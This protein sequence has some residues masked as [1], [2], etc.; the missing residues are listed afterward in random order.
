MTTPLLIKA[1]R[2]AKL[3]WEAKE[4]SDG[5]DDFVHVA[6]GPLYKERKLIARWHD[7]VRRHLMKEKRK[8][9]Q[10]NMR[11]TRSMTVSADILQSELTEEKNE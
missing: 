9:K 5:D 7:A 10:P 2:A 8:M 1:A 11:M 3:E 6:R 4:Q